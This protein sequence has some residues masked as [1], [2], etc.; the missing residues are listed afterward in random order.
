MCELYG[1]ETPETRKMMIR[2]QVKVTPTFRMYRCVE[3]A[4]MLGT[5]NLASHVPATPNAYSL[6][7]HGTKGCQPLHNGTH[8]T[9]GTQGRQHCCMQGFHAAIA[10]WTGVVTGPHRC[11]VHRLLLCVTGDC[12][13][14]EK[15]CVNVLTGTN[16]KKLMRGM[17]AHLFPAELINHEREIQDTMELEEEAPAGAAA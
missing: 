1:D 6:P 17:L 12:C 2:L 16:E 11:N 14:R 7:T 4:R 8:G 13:R 10:G 3:T 5:W 15:Q 9:Y